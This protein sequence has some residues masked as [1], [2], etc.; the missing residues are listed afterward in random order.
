[1][2]HCGRNRYEDLL[3]EL[4]F[5]N[6][7]VRLADPDGH[8][9][10]PARST[11]DRDRRMRILFTIPLLAALLGCASRKPAKPVPPPPPMIVVV[12]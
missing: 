6:E 1:M 5:R 3:V 11:Y 10:R 7:I 9:S 8:L 2:K 4:I 12:H